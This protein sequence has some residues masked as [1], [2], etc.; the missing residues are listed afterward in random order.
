MKIL[1]IEDLGG[2]ILNF[3]LLSNKVP[4]FNPD[5]RLKAFF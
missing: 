2:W 5:S 4:N 3:Q 1:K